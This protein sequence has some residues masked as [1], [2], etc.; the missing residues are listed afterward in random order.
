MLVAEAEGFSPKSEQIEL[1]VG[2][3][4][5]TFLLS[6]GRALKGRVVDSSG[7]SI[8]NALVRTGSNDQGI[9][10]FNWTTRSDIDG[11]FE[12]THAPYGEV[13]YWF[14]ADG[15]IPKR[16]QPLT[17]DGTEHQIILEPRD[18]PPSASVPR[19]I[20]ELRLVESEAGEATEALRN[21][22][23]ATKP[24]PESLQNLFVRKEPLLDVSALFSAKVETDQ[25]TGRPVINLEF[26]AEGQA[27]FAEVTRQHVGRQLAI[28]VN[29]QVLSAPVIAEPITGGKAQI[30]GNFSREEA[31]RLAQL[32]Q[33]N[34]ARKSAGVAPFTGA[35]Q[36]R[37]IL[38]GKPPLERAIT[39]MDPQSRAQHADTPTT[40]F[41]VVADDGGLRDV[42]VYLEGDLP[43]LA[44]AA[45]L[46]PLI[47]DHQRGFKVPYV[48]ALAVGQTLLLTNS[49][50]QLHNCH[51]IPPR[52]S[53]NREVNKAL[54][55]G[56]ANPHTFTA[57]DHWVRLKCDV[58]PWE[59][60]YVCV[61][62]HRYFAVTDVG[63]NFSISNVPP[64]RYKLH[65][66]HRKAKGLGPVDVEITSPAVSTLGLHLYPETALQ[67]VCHP[68]QTSYAVGD[69]ITLR[70]T[71]T[72]ISDQEQRVTWHP[73]TGSHL[74]LGQD[75]RSWWLDGREL[76]YFKPVDLRPPVRI[77]SIPGS[78][79][80][81][82][83]LPPRTSVEL[84]HKRTA[85]MPGSFRRVLAY[86]AF[87]PA[88]ITSETL[89][90]LDRET[91]FSNP[92]TYEVTERV[93]KEGQA[94]QPRTNHSV[95][96]P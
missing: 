22:V 58:H 93:E 67:L 40:Q 83:V 66:L 27:R 9:R 73:T 7:T 82:I 17:A 72:N 5:H 76:P 64:G 10:L 35:I 4:K 37:V 86:E 91:I 19:P 47:I 52:G 1:H 43:P 70:C 75:E 85:K 44:S 12:W 71:I 36:G 56:V 69:D 74:T 59:F 34:I 50:S 87:Q 55:R 2:P 48:S 81:E 53:E 26:T 32:I 90:L 38:G 88:V 8:T 68:D 65:A 33:Q 14:E 21:P 94:S 18:P 78:P 96:K 28:V 23:E 89:E 15:F 30:T 46:P 84:A 60:A 31:E 79:L 63:G 61:F 16:Q 11:R 25:F 77:E 92:F 39:G 6:K 49:D 42:V 95:E 24:L 80:S 13:L 51:I 20:F 57:P 62:P 45:D 29:G 54:M 3:N 41:Y